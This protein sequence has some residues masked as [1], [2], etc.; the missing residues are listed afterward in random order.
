[1]TGRYLTGERLVE[2]GMLLNDLSREKTIL[3][4][5]KKKKK[6]QT[7]F[8]PEGCGAEERYMATWQRTLLAVKVGIRVCLT[9]MSWTGVDCFSS[10]GLSEGERDGEKERGKRER[11]RECVCVCVWECSFF[12]EYV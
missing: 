6:S 5:I 11:E 4:H 3:S 9:Q 7:D 12:F 10:A 2:E 1:M 8:Y